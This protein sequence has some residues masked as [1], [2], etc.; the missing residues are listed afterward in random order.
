MTFIDTNFFLRFLLSDINDQ[1]Q[2]AKALLKKGA[3][4]KKSLCT[5]IIVFFELYFV[6]S[7][8]YKTNKKN[9]AD[10]LSKILKMRF[11]RLPERDLLADA[12]SLFS[13]NNV[14]LEDAYNIIYAKSLNIT[15][16]A[17]FDRKLLRL[18]T[19]LTQVCNPD[20]IGTD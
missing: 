5:S 15:D 11:V 2:T 14:S 16:F 10:I 1:H 19:H 7:S 6:L 20:L 8:F 4:G 18:Y 9:L 12:L 17:S 3:E 13:K